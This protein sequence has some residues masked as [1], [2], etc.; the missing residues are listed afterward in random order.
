MTMTSPDLATPRFSWA[1][2]PLLYM[3]YREP[4]Q[5]PATIDIIWPPLYRTVQES[6]IRPGQ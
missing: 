5:D 1:D 3:Q 2:P 6:F 4:M